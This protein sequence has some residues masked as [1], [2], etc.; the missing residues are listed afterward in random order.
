MTD[1]SEAARQARVTIRYDAPCAGISVADG[2]WLVCAT[3]RPRTGA[4]TR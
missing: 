2:G 4:T 3:L 1:V